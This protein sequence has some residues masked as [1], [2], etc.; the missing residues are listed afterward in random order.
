MGTLAATQPRSLAD[1]LRARTDEE[2]IG[3]LRARPDLLAPVPADVGQLASRAATRASVARAVDRL[4]R[5]M[6][7]VID[8]LLVLPEPATAAEVRHLLGIPSAA[9]QAALTRLRTLALVWRSGPGIRL[10]RTV[11]EILGPH[12]AGLGPA[13]LDALALRSPAY[14]ARL[15]ADLGLRST[16]DP[17]AD[18]ARLAEG[19]VARLETLLAEL[20]GEAVE[21]LRK[22]AAGPPTGRVGD[23]YRQVSRESARTPVDELLARGLIVPT[24]EATVVLPREIA[25]HLRGGVLHPSIRITPPVPAT[26]GR[27]PA[28]VD[29]TAGAGAF[30]AV[31]RVEALLEDWS[32]AP[33]PVLRQGG[34]GVRDLRRLPRLLDVDEVGAGLL[35]ELAYAT[36]L[37]APGGEVDEVWL[38][39]PAYDRWLVDE[40][41]AQ[42]TALAAAWLTSS[43]AAG[44]I[45]SRD[46][47]NRPLLPL[48]HALERPLAPQVR[49]LTLD[50]LA[51]LPAGSAAEPT[52][53]VD[54]VRWQR[55]R[56]NGRRRDELV[57][58]TLREAEALGLTGRGA[59]AGYVVPLLDD[60]PPAAARKATAA[61]L[62]A[63]LPDPLDQVL[64]QTDLT[65]VAPGPLR[66]DLARELSLLSDVESRGG[67][68]VHR[69][70]PESIR[71][72]LDAGRSA[73]DLHEFL[74]AL[75]RTPVPQP[76]SYLVD[77][78]ARRHGR[79]RVGAAAGFVR[80][81]DPAVLAEI[82][83][84]SRAAALGLRRI[85]PTVLVSA[86]EPATLLDRL[87]AIGFAP[88]AEGPDGSVV[89]RP[90]ER[91]RAPDRPAPTP[92]Q[93]DHPVPDERLLTAAVRA[94][95][96]GEQSTARRPRGGP[97]VRL[98]R[99]GTAQ[100]LG[101][102]RRALEHGHTLWLGYVN[103]DGVTS[104]RVV[105]PIRLEG[106]WLTA[107]D[108][109]AGDVRSFAVHRI[110]GVAPAGAGS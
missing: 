61:G 80:S 14:L 23:A 81:D 99:G 75:S 102:L 100:V 39:T 8:A 110:S 109:R 48:S 60:R 42:W 65:A 53:V 69:F 105:D 32:K 66:P 52:E 104:E 97:P 83:A 3:L 108:H 35:A 93:T 63:V 7:Q 27:D 67:A 55:P 36:G 29:R 15:C 107:F 21:A 1:D 51:A 57:R 88:A 4:D 62:A 6:L 71:R 87:S 20:S 106:G 58:W 73:A 76:L 13:L 46:E 49:R 89:V 34:L 19:V 5:F 74:R 95:R 31:R 26:V 72:A 22:L 94:V 43:R 44:L 12:P 91:R 25:L 38:P 9:A 103:Q 70:T 45:G 47:R 54:A 33:P 96:A 17:A 16:G 10:V 92:V 59:L 50:V 79:L 82:L 101:E 86:L 2:L 28:A 64:I 40:P 11:R 30:E 90:T 78:V 37:V 77:D 68:S 41:A 84:D 18:A 56:W 24:D 85:A 98:G